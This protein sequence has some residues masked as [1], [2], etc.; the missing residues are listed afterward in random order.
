MAT[1]QSNTPVTTGNSTPSSNSTPSILDQILN[2]DPKFVKLQKSNDQKAKDEANAAAKL[3]LNDYVTQLPDASEL[4]QKKAAVAVIQDLIK[5]VDEKLS[6]DVSA[7]LHDP[8][9][10]ELEASWRGLRYLVFNTDTSKTLKLRLLSVKRGTLEKDLRNAVDTD[11]SVLFKKVYEEEYGTYGGNPFSLLI[12][13]LKFGK[14]ATDIELL[15]NISKVASAAHTPFIAAASPDLFNMDSFTEL[16]VPRDISK[17]FE[18]P[19]LAAFNSFRKSEDA[20]YVTLTLPRFLLRLPY[21]DTTIKS[22]NFGMD[23]NL[24]PEAPAGNGAPAT[25]HHKYLWGNSAYALGVRITSAFAKYGWCAAIRGPEGGG[26]VTNLPMHIFDT[27][28]GDKAMKCPT[29]VSITDR[30][31]KELNDLGF[32]SL[33]HC[34]G[35]NF[36]AFFGGQTTHKPPKFD[37]EAANAN[38]ALSARLPYL[39]AASRFAHYLKVMCRDKIGTFQT[40]ETMALYL[41][42]WIMLYVLATD[43]AGQDVKAQFPLRD[44]RIDVTEK[45][46]EP[47]AFRAVCFLR[48]HFQLEELTTSIRLVAE[49]PPPV[50][51]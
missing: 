7:I 24:V 1:R 46:G 49:L 51:A 43:D 20:R 15:T 12:G 33:V 34:K 31:E 22:E 13:D 10:T 50:A 11:Q 38:A 28:E 48:P 41:N 45:P 6:A 4:E 16:G 30:R 42:R 29:E 2:T 27:E 17:V 25:N 44:A 32:V 40:K 14:G 8:V 35:T 5:K 19:Q 18:T 36:A 21:G 47:G 26:K 23:E 39:L 9:F 37:L 3:I